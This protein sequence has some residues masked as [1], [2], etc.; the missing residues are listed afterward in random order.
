MQITHIKQTFST[1]ITC[2]RMEMFKNDLG[3]EKDI[4]AN[5]F[6]LTSFQVRFALIGEI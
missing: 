5:L 6:P 2:S 4:E 3:K 1:V